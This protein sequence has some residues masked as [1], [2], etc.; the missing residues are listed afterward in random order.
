MIFEAP[1]L[2]RCDGEPFATIVRYGYETP[3]ATAQLRADD[4]AALDRA[5]R[6][7]A[8]DRWS[9]EQAEELTGDEYDAQYE[10]ERVRL[11]LSDADVRHHESA[12][13]TIVTADGT[14]R[15]AYSLD[16]ADG[17]IQWRW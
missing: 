12:A 7:A 17:H 16:F 5:N 1:M 9:C 11:G 10:R 14:E 6:A 13:W 4:P 2:L 15:R 8:L 3:W